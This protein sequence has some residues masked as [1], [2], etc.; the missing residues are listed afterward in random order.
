MMQSFTVS[1]DDPYSSLR[2]I[3]VAEDGPGFGPMFDGNP[4][5]NWHGDL[6][7]SHAYDGFCIDFAFRLV[8]AFITF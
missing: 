6:V 4:N 1:L 3:Q 7:G 5:T 2:N 8:K